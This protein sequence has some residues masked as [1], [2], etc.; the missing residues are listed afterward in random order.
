MREEGGK[1]FD[2][3]GYYAYPGPLRINTETMK[4]KAVS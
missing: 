3:Q 2:M 1:I 4:L